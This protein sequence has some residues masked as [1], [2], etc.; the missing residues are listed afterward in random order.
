[1]NVL[2]NIPAIPFELRLSRA[3]DPPRLRICTIVLDLV[4]RPGEETS[5]TVPQ[6]YFWP[7]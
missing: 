6:P 5:F 2:Q 7:S 3:L 1:M 4:W